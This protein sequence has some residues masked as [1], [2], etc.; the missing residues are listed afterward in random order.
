MQLPWDRIFNLGDESND[1]DDGEPSA[2]GASSRQ[3]ML[4]L[5]PAQIEVRIQSDECIGWWK[6]NKSSSSSSPVVKVKRL[7]LQRAS[8]E[9]V[10]TA[11]AVEESSPVAAQDE[12]QSEEAVPEPKTRVT[13]SSGS[14]LEDGERK[15]NEILGLPKMVIRKTSCRQYK[16]FLRSH[17][18]LEPLVCLTKNKKLDELALKCSSGELLHIRVEDIESAEQVLSLI[19]ISEPTRPY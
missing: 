12:P 15:L 18:I 1:G 3:R 2:A 8:T 9:V 17:R 5:G 6:T 14:S 13:R 10:D 19:H 7:V 11:A 4:E 16:S